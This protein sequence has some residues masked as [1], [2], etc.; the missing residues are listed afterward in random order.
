MHKM[1]SKWMAQ[2]IHRWHFFLSQSFFFPVIVTFKCVNCICHKYDLNRL[3]LILI[4]RELKMPFQSKTDLKAKEIS[5]LKD[6]QAKKISK[7]K[8]SKESIY[9]KQT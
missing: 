6:F 4:V 3:R 2:Q 7:Q 9:F 1:L 8:D 5:K